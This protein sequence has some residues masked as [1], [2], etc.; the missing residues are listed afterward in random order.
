MKVC[1][2]PGCPNHVTRH[3]RCAGHASAQARRRARAR[4]PR[5]YDTRRWQLTRRRVLFDRPLCEHD[6]CDEL[7]VDV[8][9]LETPE[10]RPTLPTPSRTSKRCATPITPPPLGRNPQRGQADDTG[11]V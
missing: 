3:G 8:H 7:A 9:H 1:L 4:G 10:D 11:G 5:I 2:E 6:G